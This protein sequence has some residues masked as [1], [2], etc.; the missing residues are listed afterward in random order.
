MA[1][2]NK[3]N[4]NK[5]QMK[6]QNQ[7]NQNNNNRKKVIVKR[8]I[9]N[10]RK[11]IQETLN[12]VKGTVNEVNITAPMGEGYRHKNLPPKFNKGKSFTV[13]HREYVGN[14]AGSTDLQVVKLR[15]N[16][17]DTV[18]F[19]WLS[20][21]ASSFEKWSMKSMKVEYVKN[22]PS[23]TE[24]YIFLYPDYDVNR[25]AMTKESDFLNTMDA[26]DS[27]AWV[28]ANLVIKPGKF[29]QT[30]GDTYLVRSPFQEYK[31]YLLYDPV[32]IYVGTAGTGDLPSLGR[33][34]I[35]YTIELKIP[36]PESN[37]HLY[38]Y[39]AGWGAIG[40]IEWPTGSGNFLPEPG[41][42]SIISVNRG[43][44]W[45]AP[46]SKYPTGFVFDDYFC[47][48]FTVYMA[49]S[50]GLDSSRVMGMSIDHGEILEVGWMNSDVLGG[51]DIWTA[52]FAIK[53][54]DPKANLWFTG[55][56]LPDVSNRITGMWIMAASANPKWIF[57]VAPSALDP[58]PTSLNQLALMSELK[59]PQLLVRKDKNPVIE[60]NRFFDESCDD[61]SVELY[62][63][64]HQTRR[65]FPSKIQ[66]GKESRLEWSN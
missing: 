5:N 62:P 51:P 44:L 65:T 37:L 23:I 13:T 46:S 52:T 50:N 43:N 39:D 25:P 53:T 20:T 31:D 32:N 22:C 7:R 11:L 60:N 56:L 6:N 66:P 24:G 30:K 64:Y 55:K 1:R 36:D 59:G 4:Q 21:I 63:R 26:V 41:S 47:G 34:Y 40:T 58:N 54:T 8:R 9:P 49:V 57:N 17:S 61:D 14:L 45:L 29:S 12:N 19:P 38:N 42:A 3:N 28:N 18:T 16:P 10:L 35:T 33:I 48:L 2:K 15:V 27:S